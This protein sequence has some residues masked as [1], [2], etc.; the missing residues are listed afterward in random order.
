VSGLVG[1][2]TLGLTLAVAELLAALGQL[3]GVSTC[4]HSSSGLLAEPLGPVQRACA[5]AFMRGVR[6]IPA[7]RYQYFN[8]GFTGSPVRSAE[9]RGAVGQVSAV[10]APAITVSPTIETSRT[11]RGREPRRKPVERERA[12]AMTQDYVIP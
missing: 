3:F 10:T 9:S 4:F 1:V 5:E 8:V 11:R 12:S 7:G 6:V 2:V